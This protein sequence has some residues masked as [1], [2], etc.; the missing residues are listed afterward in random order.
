V[1]QR[2]YVIKW[3]GG[4]TDIYADSPQE[5]LMSAE[6]IAQELE[7]EAVEVWLLS[8]DKLIYV[9]SKP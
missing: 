6:E 8:V 4:D 7:V 1:I 2:R 5:A 3:D 9:G